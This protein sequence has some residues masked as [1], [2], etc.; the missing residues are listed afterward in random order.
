MT[1]CGLPVSRILK[2]V[3]LWYFGSEG[4]KTVEPEDLWCKGSLV[5]KSPGPLVSIPRGVQAVK[6]DA[7]LSQIL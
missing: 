3:N 4:P 7:V 1:L 5:Y 6:E 2:P